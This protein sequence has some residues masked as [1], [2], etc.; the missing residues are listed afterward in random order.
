M[1][2]RDVR[3]EPVCLSPQPALAKDATRE[4]CISAGARR[5]HSGGRRDDVLRDHLAAESIADGTRHHRSGCGRL[6]FWPQEKRG[7]S[8]IGCIPAVMRAKFCVDGL[9]TGKTFLR[10]VPEADAF[11]TEFPAEIHF[12]AAKQGGEIDQTDVKIFDQT[13]GFLNFLDSGL[14]ALGALV[15]AQ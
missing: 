7:R 1:F 4:L 12:V 2:H 14:Q 6:S 9:A 15:A 13:T 5:L 10:S 3:R 11:L 8:L